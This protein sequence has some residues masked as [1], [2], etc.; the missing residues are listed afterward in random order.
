MDRRRLFFLSVLPASSWNPLCRQ[1]V[2]AKIALAVEVSFCF[3]NTPPPSLSPPF[4]GLSFFFSSLL[5]APL[6]PHPC[7]RNNVFPRRLSCRRAA[8]GI[9]KR[10]LGRAR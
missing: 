10:T 2:S 3:T 7:L 9:I 6:F 5:Q 8:V 4:A 1:Y